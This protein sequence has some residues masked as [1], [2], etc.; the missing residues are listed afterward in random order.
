MVMT[1][2]WILMRESPQ[3]QS[4]ERTRRDTATVIMIAVVVV[5]A[6]VFLVVV[7]ALVVVI[8]VLPLLVSRCYFTLCDYRN[9]MR[10]SVLIIVYLWFAG[11]SFAFSS[12]CNP[13]SY[14][15]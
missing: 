1:D 8:V 13:Q 4:H 11:L 10:W 12:S 3:A 5:V 2:C 7:I 9:K 14:W 15:F 6:V